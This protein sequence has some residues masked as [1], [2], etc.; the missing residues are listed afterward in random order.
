MKYSL[1]TEMLYDQLDFIDRFKAAA[2]DGFEYAEFWR[3]DGRDWDA[4]KKAVS[5]SGLKISAFS[6]DDKFSPVDAGEKA[7][8]LD[9]LEKSIKKAVDLECPNLV[10]HSD[11]LNPED[12]SAKNLG[13]DLSYETKLLNLYDVLK[14]AAVIAENAG[15]TLVLEPLN[16]LVDH[17]NYFLSD[18]DVSFD[19][20]RSVGSDSIKLLYDIYHM[21]IMKGNVIDRIIKN[22][23]CIGYFHAADVPGRHE[24]GTGELA[25]ENIFKALKE[26]GYNGF[27]GFELSPADDNGSAIKAIRKSMM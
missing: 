26:A 2:D 18:P 15:V 14:D 23:D 20:I 12:G 6:G 16:T 27:A 3:W 11:A 21:Q 25:Y 5:D 10:I 13:R 19:L 1:C 9:F 7:D 17:K 22:I 8:Y 24:P 4:V